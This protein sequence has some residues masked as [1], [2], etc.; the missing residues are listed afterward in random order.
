M[1]IPTWDQLIAAGEA[2]ITWGFRIIVSG[3][4]TILIGLVIIVA[5]AILSNKQTVKIIK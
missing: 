2:L 3:V 1:S 5:V 4:I